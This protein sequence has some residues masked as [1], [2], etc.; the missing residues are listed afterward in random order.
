MQPLVKTRPRCD[1]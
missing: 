1:L